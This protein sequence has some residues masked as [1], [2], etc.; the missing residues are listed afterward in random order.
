MHEISEANNY[1]KG[2]VGGERGLFFFIFFF[3]TWVFVLSWEALVGG[4]HSLFESG[5]DPN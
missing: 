3:G 2:G 5:V 1:P 4:L